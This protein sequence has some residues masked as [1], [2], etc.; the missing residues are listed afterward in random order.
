VSLTILNAY[1]EVITAADVQ[2]EDKGSHRIA[3]IRAPGYKRRT[4][5]LRGA[6]KPQRIFLGFD[7]DTATVPDIPNL[8]AAAATNFHAAMRF[9]PVYG[10]TLGKLVL[11]V[12]HAQQ[13]RIFYHVKAA[14][15]DGHIDSFNHSEAW[16]PADSS[17]HHGPPGET[18]WTNKGGWKQTQAEPG[19]QII[20]WWSRVTGYVFEVDIDEHKDIFGHAYEVLRNHSTGRLTH[21]HV[22]NQ[23][24]A[25]KR[26]ILSYRLEPAAV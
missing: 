5:V 17:L 4:V 21:P 22:I 14:V 3:R 12:M 15:T 11:G 8:E 19:I 16:E 7:L 24:L 25:R 1:G 20:A 23:A 9:A 6:G 2:A 26:G 10:T 18:V 13:D